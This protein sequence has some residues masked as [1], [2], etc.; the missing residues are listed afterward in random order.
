MRPIYSDLPRKTP[1]GEQYGVSLYCGNLWVR[2]NIWQPF[3]FKEHF[4]QI[5]LLEDT[6][7]LFT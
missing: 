2:E 1:D 7:S 3:I 4:Y 6:F 5:K